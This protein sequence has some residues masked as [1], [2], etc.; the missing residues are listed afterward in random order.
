VK[1]KGL[2]LPS[3][4]F[5]KKK[6]KKSAKILRW[7]FFTHPNME[8]S[9]EPGLPLFITLA[10][11][12]RAGAWTSDTRRVCFPPNSSAT[13]SRSGVCYSLINSYT[14]YLKA[15]TDSPG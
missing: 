12:E 2:F 4:T 9:R 13:P 6:K 7:H 1:G 14:I 15:A 3:L 11:R 5:L 8:A 10:G